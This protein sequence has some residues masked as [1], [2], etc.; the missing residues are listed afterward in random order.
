[1][2]TEDV[3]DHAPK[4]Q[5]LSYAVSLLENENLGK[6][7]AHVSATDLDDSSNGRVSYSLVESLDSK[8]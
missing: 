5:Q 8:L 1:M 6:A 4:F 7:I 2:I 3:N